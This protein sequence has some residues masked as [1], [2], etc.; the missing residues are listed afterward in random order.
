MYWFLK[1]MRTNIRFCKDSRGVIKFR[2]ISLKGQCHE[3]FGF[4]FAEKIEMITC[5]VRIPR[6][7]WDCRI[8]FRGLNETAE[9]NPA[10]SMRPQNQIP[11]FQWDRGNQSRGLIETAETDDK[12]FQ[13]YLCIFGCS[14]PESHN[15]SC[16]IPRSHW[17]RGIGFCGVNETAEIL[18]HLGNPYRNEY[19]FSFPLKGNH[20]KNLYI[21][22]H[23]IPIVTRKRQY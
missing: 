1:G 11:R 17:D 9:S 4:V 12:N 23:C 15:F 20:C 10:V 5:K 14:L 21:C 19:W 6:S 2:W 8:G 3:I 16:R 7:Q 18:W 22:K 13:F